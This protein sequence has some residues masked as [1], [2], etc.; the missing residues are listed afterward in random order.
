MFPCLTL[1]L[2][3]SLSNNKSKICF[4]CDA[5]IHFNQKLAGAHMG[6]ACTYQ[7]LPDCFTIHKI[8]G[9]RTRHGNFLVSIVKTYDFTYE[10]FDFLGP[11]YQVLELKL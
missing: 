11:E 9:S 8:V 2:F 1:K 4:L 7:A 5:F 3:S 6:G 10:N